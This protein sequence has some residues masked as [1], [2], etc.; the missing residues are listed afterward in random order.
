MRNTTFLFA[1]FSKHKID[2]VIHFAALKSV[3]ESIENP[4]AY[5]DTNLNGLLTLIK[6]DRVT[7]G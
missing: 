5:Y 1:L 3:R 4:L 7:Y 2:A 6:R